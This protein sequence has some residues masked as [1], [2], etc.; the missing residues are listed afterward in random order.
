[1]PHTLFHTRGEGSVTF[2]V[3]LHGMKM[4]PKI[5]NKISFFFYKKETTHTQSSPVIYGS[6]FRRF[7]SFAGEKT[8]IYRFCNDSK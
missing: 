5:S 4:L 6:I 8:L 2:E 1:M 3:K 7:T